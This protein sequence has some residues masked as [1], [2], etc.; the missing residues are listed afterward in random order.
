MPVTINAGRGTKKVKHPSGRAAK[1]GDIKAGEVVVIN[2]KT[3]RIE[4]PKANRPKRKRK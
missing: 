2:A 3:G 4:P 1:A